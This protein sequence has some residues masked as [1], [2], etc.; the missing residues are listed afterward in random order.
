M[1]IDGSTNNVTAIE[2]DMR[3]VLRAER[4]DYQM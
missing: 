4:L 1:S 2:M 3:D